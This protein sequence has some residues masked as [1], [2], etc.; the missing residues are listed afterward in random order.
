MF[1]RNSLFLSIAALVSAGTIRSED[2]SRPV[3]FE[4]NQ[5]QAPSGVG[6][7]VRSATHNIYFGKTEP[8]FTLFDGNSAVTMRFK[9]SATSIAQPGS[10][11]ETTSNFLLG[12]D[13]AKWRRNVRNLS[14]IRY[15]HI[16]PGV[17]A[18]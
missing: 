11:T 7:I 12:K 8:R 16:Y 15:Q 1:L 10:A 2:F 17:D 13:P 14:S 18:V 6:F 9:G 5:G 3:L 4:V